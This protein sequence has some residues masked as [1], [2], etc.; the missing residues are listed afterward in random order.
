MVAQQFFRREGHVFFIRHVAIEIRQ[1]QLH[2]LDGEMKRLH[3]IRVMLLNAALLKNAERNQRG[4]PLT[5]WRQFLN[6]AAREVARQ[7]VNPVHAVVCQI[8]CR[9]MRTVFFGKGGNFLRQLAAVKRVTVG[10]RNQ[11]QRVRLRRVT[12]DF[13]HARGAAF[14][15]E[16]GAEA[17][18]IFQLAIASL[19]EMTNQRRDGK[20]VAR[21]VNGRLRQ[22]GQRQRA[23]ALRQRDPAGYRS[24][25]GHRV[26]ANFRH[27]AFSGKQI[28]MPAGRRAA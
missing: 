6:R 13:P 21:V 7:Q 16:A 17:R 25:H 28:R 4:D 1:R 5:V 15:R 27:C 18:L 10:F 8:L 23:E 3:G 19:P 12:E 24:R 26:P 11:L 20:A 22:R 9:Q 2:R 14:R